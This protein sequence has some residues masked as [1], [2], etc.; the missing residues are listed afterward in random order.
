MTTDGGPLFQ[1]PAGSPLSSVHRFYPENGEP[2]TGNYFFQLTTCNSEHATALLTHP[3]G[4]KEVIAF[5][6]LLQ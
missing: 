2:T 5:L 3:N 4:R 1:R 6:L